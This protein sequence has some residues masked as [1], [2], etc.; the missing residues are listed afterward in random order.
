VKKKIPVPT[1]KRLLMY[2]HTLENF[3]QRGKEYVSSQELA[4]MLEITDTQ[5]RKDLAFFENI[6]KRGKGYS[7]K[8]MIKKIKRM[9]GLT[10]RTNV[11]IVGI[12]NL[13]TAL[14]ASNLLRDRGFNIIAGFD[15]DI[16]KIY[17]DCCGIRILL[18]REIQKTVRDKG[19]KIAILTTPGSVAQE[20][21]DKLYNAGIRGILNFTP[22]KLNLPSNCIVHNVDFSVELEFLKFFV[23]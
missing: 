4:Q 9:F 3:V 12:G 21:A 22:V 17:K 13:G 5:V 10:K 18:D 23:K 11:I 16:K 14:L 19:V 6:G 2:L 15:S 20:V 8:S 1:V 7:I